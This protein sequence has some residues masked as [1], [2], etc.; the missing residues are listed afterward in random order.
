MTGGRFH[1]LAIL[2]FTAD[3]LSIIATKVGTPLMLISYTNS[4][5]MESWGKSGFSRALI[6][7]ELKGAMNAPKVKKVGKTKGPN[8]S[9]N[10]KIL[11]A[12]D[13]L[14]SITEEDENT[15][16][17]PSYE[18]VGNHMKILGQQTVML[19]EIAKPCISRVS[20]DG[21]QKGRYCGK[22]RYTQKK[23]LPKSGHAEMYDS[24]E[25]YDHIMSPT[26]TI[27]AEDDTEDEVEFCSFFCSL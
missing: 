27:C 17:V 3:G 25:E 8:A 6:D 7:V 26:T 10:T 16:C 1:E 5:C 2:A 21:R 14:N 15:T 20:G 23:E 4:M 13:V 12:F 9:T 19:D 24:Y 22:Y 18:K 11:N